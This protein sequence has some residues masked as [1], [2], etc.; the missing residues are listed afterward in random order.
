VYTVRRLA[1]L[2]GVSVRTLH[3]Y[4][5]IGLLKPSSV[6]GNG[7]RYYDAEALYRLQ[8]VPFYR[9]LGLPLREIKTILGRRDFD[10]LKAL[11]SHR[12][13]LQAD[14]KRLRLLIRTVDRTTKQLRG[15]SSMNPKRLFD[16][17]SEAQQARYA[18]EAARHWGEQEVKASNDKWKAYS[19]EEKARILEEGNALY[20]DLAAVMEKGASSPQV[21]A[22]IARWHAHL[23]HFWSPSDD[24][25]LGPAD[26]YND[27]PRF[28]ANY[29]A[30]AT[31]MA[32]FM[33]EAVQVYVKNRR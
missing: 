10:V 3:Y 33:R 30:F 4:D 22:V 24:Q 29:E 23:Q 8:Q 21:Q 13:A 31:G 12:V 26:L 25:L 19:P 17:F 6:G 15:E 14:V 5:Q 2:A 18:R 27:D 32:A 11:Q 7:Y 1:E 16:G 9:E 20:A 28:R